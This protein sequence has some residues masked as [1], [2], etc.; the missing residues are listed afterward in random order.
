MKFIMKLILLAFIV[1]A[2]L[3]AGEKLGFW[4]LMQDSSE[5]KIDKTA[6]IVE[7]IK[8]ISEFTSVSFYEEFALHEQKAS[9][10]VDNKAGQAIAKLMNKDAKDLSSDDIVI[11]AK[12]KVRAGIDLSQINDSTLHISHD[13][14]RMKLPTASIFDVIINPSG[15]EIY[16]ENGNWSHEQVTAVEAKASEQLKNDAIANGILDKATQSG[17]TQLSNLFKAFGY[18]VVEFEE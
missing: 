18:A 14:L 4:K 12:G 3:Y 1:C 8:K 10:L 16:E 6:N 2:V 9:K 11:I 17:K 13:T 15:F 5:L 7:E